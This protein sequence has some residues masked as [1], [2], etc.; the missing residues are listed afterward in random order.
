M[1]YKAKTMPYNMHIGDAIK[2]YKNELYK[3]RKEMLDE[4]T[5]SLTYGMLLGYKKICLTKLDELKALDRRGIKK[6][7]VIEKGTNVMD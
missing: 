2:W 6:V 1:I 5:D 7:N 3:I 4:S